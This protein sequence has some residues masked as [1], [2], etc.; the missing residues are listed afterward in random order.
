MR[1]VS[2]ARLGSPVRT[3]WVAS[4]RS[5]RHQLGALQRDREVTGEGLEQGEVIGGEGGRVTES[6][7]GH[8]RAAGAAPGQGHDQ[9]I[10]DVVVAKPAALNRHS[11]C[12]CVISRRRQ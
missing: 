4:C 9:R 7:Q 11:S 3:S 6:V 8:Q 5:L 2:S 10:L 1:A 12:D